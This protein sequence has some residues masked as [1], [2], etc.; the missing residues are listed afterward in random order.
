MIEMINE[1]PIIASIAVVVVGVSFVAITLRKEMNLEKEIPQEEGKPNIS[2]RLEYDRD[3]GAV[4]YVVENKGT[5]AAHNLK[6]YLPSCH[7]IAKSRSGMNSEF[8]AASVLKVGMRTYD[9]LGPKEIDNIPLFQ[10][11]PTDEC[12]K[13]I[14]GLG[15]EVE[16]RWTNTKGDLKERDFVLQVNSKGRSQGLTP[17]PA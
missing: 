1:T 5:A 7:Q 2:V 3:T 6:V 15:L 14:H 9:R 8:I 10:L 12:R 16:M 4:F 13:E 11:P 17:I